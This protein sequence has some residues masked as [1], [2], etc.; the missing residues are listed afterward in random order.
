MVLDSV[1]DFD[2]FFDESQRREATVVRSN[3]P[4]SLAK[5]LPK[6][7]NGSILVT[8]RNK[9]TAAKLTGGH[10]NIREVRVMD[11]SEGQKLLCTK[12][13]V[14]PSQ[15]MAA[16]LVSS[17]DHIPL[18]IS[19]AAAYINRNAHMDIDHYVTELRA[20]KNKESLLR[21]ESDDLRR[22][23]SASN[24]V[25]AAWQMSFNRIQQERP[26]AVDLLSFLGFFNPQSIPVW[27][28]QSCNNETRN[29][30]DDENCFEKDLNLLQAFCFVAVTT[31]SKTYEMHPLV[32]SCT[33]LWL[34]SVGD[35]KSFE[36]EFTQ[37]MAR[38]F[39][40]ASFDTWAEC[41]ELLPHVER[42]LEI[43]VADETALGAWSQVIGDAVEFMVLQGAHKAGN[44]AAVRLFS[45]SQKLMGPDH[46]ITLK[47]IDVLGTV[48]RAQGRFD[49]AEALW[50]QAFTGQVKAHGQNHRTT[51]STASNLAMVLRDLGKLGE[52]E[53]LNKQTLALCEDTLGL[54]DEQTLRTEVQ[55]ALVLHG[56]GRYEEAERH[57]RRVLESR[58]RSLGIKHI[59]TLLS[60]NSLGGVLHAQE[61]YSEAE[62]LYR[63]ALEGRKHILLEGHPSTL[64]SMN[65]LASVLLDQE[66]DGDEA[67]MLS[68]QVLK[69]REKADEEHPHTFTSI[70]NLARVLE[71]RGK[72][73]EAEALCRRALLGRESTLGQDHIDTLL[74]AN[75]LAMLLKGLKRYDEATPFFQRACNGLEKSLGHEHP[76]TIT[77]RGNFSDMQL[78][79]QQTHRQSLSLYARA[80]ARM[81][82]RNT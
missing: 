21:W 62:A 53:K 76:W 4:K 39:P 23:E 43:D 59:E 3:Q 31:G 48:M 32:Q 46:Q 7:S 79:T 58:D 18:A 35:V 49:D 13:I 19:Q 56:L 57:H 66:K 52:A 50:Q 72:L 29:Q 17:L 78:E 51:L 6:S 26:S 73:D 15:K 80:K 70:S 37:L 63:Q 60:M 69:W 2:I 25:V 47:S 5:Y 34:T 71:A 68:R 44:T 75:N 1:D 12:L 77:C 55:L 14:A 36:S 33:R 81:Q 67:E 45:V 64:T 20:N 28:L 38:V 22:D 27:I 41:Q 8:S 54:D 24:S 40:N 61:K 42:L 65:N 11:A 30:N 9:D 82:R 10:N 74:S 16:E